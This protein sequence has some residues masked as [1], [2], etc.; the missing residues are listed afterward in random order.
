[1][2]SYL[3]LISYPKKDNIGNTVCLIGQE[4]QYKI[5]DALRFYLM[6]GQRHDS[7]D[8]NEEGSWSTN[9]EKSIEIWSMFPN[10]YNCLDYGTIKYV[11]ESEVE[12]YY[13]RI[14]NM[15]KEYVSDVDHLISNGVSD[16]EM[17]IDFCNDFKSLSQ[18][19][20]RHIL[21]SWG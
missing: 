5:S 8:L 15:I 16:L 20:N 17:M 10:L 19:A 4:E 14:V 3:S 13:E 1:M 12:E 11:P 6:T 2:G 18:Q 7:R 21:F 9:Y